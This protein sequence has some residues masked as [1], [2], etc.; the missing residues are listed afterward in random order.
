MARQVIEAL[1]CD[2]RGDVIV[3]EQSFVT[4]VAARLLRQDVGLT[5][6]ADG[7]VLGAVDRDADEVRRRIRV[8]DVG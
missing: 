1:R 7:V 8:G 2:D 6:V 5:A 4:V 3:S